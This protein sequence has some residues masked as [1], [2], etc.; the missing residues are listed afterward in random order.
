MKTFKESGGM[1]NE[2]EV[3]LSSV[4]LATLSEWVGIS[5]LLCC[6][7]RQRPSRTDNQT[8][9]VVNRQ[10]YGRGGWTGQWKHYCHCQR[11]LYS[12]VRERVGLGLLQTISM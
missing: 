3:A 7:R 9:H 4:F 1:T 11:S 12:F 2:M 6:I 8:S 5:A 10:T